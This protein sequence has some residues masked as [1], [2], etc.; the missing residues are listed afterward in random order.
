MPNVGF[1]VLPSPPRPD[2]ALVAAFKSIPT[3][4]I[5]D[6]TNRVHSVGGGIRPYHQPAA[7]AGVALTVKVPPGQNLMVQ[8][9][10]DMAVPGDV[11][12]IDAAGDVTH[13]MI[14]EIVVAHARS[15]GVVGFVI[16]GAVRDV[17]AIRASTFPIYAAGVTHRGPYRDGPGEVNVPVAIGGLV[18]RPGDII[19]GDE[20]GVVTVPPEAAE[21]ILELTRAHAAREVVLLKAA[22][23]GTLD[24]RWV[25][26]RLRE[27]GCDF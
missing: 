15:R 19:V 23:E 24:R 6:N 18:I 27:Q 7:L 5:S 25:D 13:A 2:A 3:T 20:D 12:V 8:K 26:E 4:L 21:H 17:A 9:A 11:I 16:D 14:G 22:R 1:R 10:V